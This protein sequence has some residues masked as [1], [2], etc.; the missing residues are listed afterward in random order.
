M[1]ALLVVALLA[2]DASDTRSVWLYNTHTHEELRVRPFAD[3]G[4]PSPAAWRS[5]NRFFRSWRTDHQRPVRPR[6]MAVL[7]H[8]QRHFGG[9]RIA[10]VSGYRQLDEVRSLH[11]VGRAADI[12]I[13]GIEARALFDYCRTLVSVGCGFYPRGHHVHVDVRARAAVWVDLSRPGRA[14]RYVSEPRAWLRN[15]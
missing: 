15:H 14:P 6:L 10:L 12:I 8:L 1:L 11:N 9:R 2:G 4:R 5:I 13:E 3:G 7:V